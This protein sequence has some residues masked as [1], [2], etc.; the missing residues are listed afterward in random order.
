MTEGEA[1][2][3]RELL[4]EFEESPPE[5]AGGVGAAT[6]IG[7]AAS[8]AAKLARAGA[9]ALAAQAVALRERAGRLAGADAEAYAH[10]L[11]LLASI[12][13]DPPPGSAPLAPSLS[14]AADV[15]LDL[16]RTAGDAVTLNEQ[17]AERGDPALRDDAVA[18][19]MLAAGG[20]R[21]AAHLLEVNL[22]VRPDDDR[23][24]QARQLTAIADETV[25][26]LESRE[27][28]RLPA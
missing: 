14:R 8:L 5:I 23:V 13:V 24:A 9:P 3:L 12:E 1:L 20:G 11:Q 2:P 15:L 28:T 16:V 19:A 22:V 10:A 25:R 26:R 4:R 7:L 6:V 27:Q 21:A 18:A 17:L